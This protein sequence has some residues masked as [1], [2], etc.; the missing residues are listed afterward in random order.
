MLLTG[1]LPRTW[2]A[3]FALTPF[4]QRQRS[5]I[6][7][8]QYGDTDSADFFRYA[9]AEDRAMV[10]EAKLAALPAAEA[11]AMETEAKLAVKPTCGMCSMQ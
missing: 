10:A 9:A 4:F 1:G 6:P 5:K 7:A 3:L 2:R 8:F 11:R